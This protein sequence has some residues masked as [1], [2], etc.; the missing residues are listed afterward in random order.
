MEQ[1]SEDRAPR[2]AEARRWTWASTWRGVAVASVVSGLAGVVVGL[3]MPRG[4]VTTAQAL[5]SLVLGLVAGAG[6]GY[7]LRTRWSMLAAPLALV[8]GV[9]LARLGVEGPSVDP[10]RFDSIYGVVALVTGRLFHG[11]LLI[12]PAALG[13]ALGGR[14]GPT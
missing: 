8:V 11:V 12:V 9:E 1:P 14:S 10:P 2:M 6:A 7:A 5:G 13:A 4:P 3:W